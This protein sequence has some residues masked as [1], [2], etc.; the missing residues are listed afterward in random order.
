[1]TLPEYIA[2]DSLSGE[3]FRAVY[4]LSG[5]KATARAKADDI[6]IEQTVE[7]PAELVPPGDI[8]D[9]IF[10]RIED[11]TQ[12]GDE[13]YAATVSYANETA[14]S[15]L[16]QFLNVVFGNI[17]IKPGIRLIRLELNNAKLA[18]FQG[19]RFGR[20]GLR[21]LVNAGVRSTERVLV[22]AYQHSP[23]MRA[24]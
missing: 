14:G 13:T 8:R 21:E 18:E 6:I 19:P 3:R 24:C 23:S 15:D 22:P 5:D 2:V 11:F 10:G 17:S 12:V 4:H 1:M 9:H 16:I 20:A 7:F